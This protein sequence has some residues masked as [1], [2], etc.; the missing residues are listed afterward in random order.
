MA[1]EIEGL[2]TPK[3][4]AGRRHLHPAS[5]PG[6]GAGQMSRTRALLGEVIIQRQTSRRRPACR[7]SHERPSGAD[8]DVG[9]R[10]VRTST[11]S[12]S[13]RVE[14][15]RNGDDR[16]QRHGASPLGPQPSFAVPRSCC[17]CR[18]RLRARNSLVSAW[19]VVSIRHDDAWL[20]M[21]LLGANLL[22]AGSMLLAIF[23]NWSRRAP[24]PTTSAPKRGRRWRSSSRLAESRRPWSPHD[25]IGA[26]SELAAGPTCDHR[27]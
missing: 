5:Q 27:R 24:R 2:D 4:R 17:V 16:G 8:S 6:I 20:T 12:T 21:P 25:R 13:L 7:S 18:R 10:Y 19:M 3:K 14:V 9:A 26:R 1:E 23:N 22:T 15:S 11:Q